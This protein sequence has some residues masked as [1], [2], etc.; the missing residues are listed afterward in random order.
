MKPWYSRAV[1]ILYAV[2]VLVPTLSLAGIVSSGVEVMALAERVPDFVDQ[3]FERAR[4]TRESIAFVVNGTDWFQRGYA[5]WSPRFWRRAGC[6]MR[7]AGSPA[8]PA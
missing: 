5:P 7:C 2:A 3:V 6:P 4:L 1:P 8:P